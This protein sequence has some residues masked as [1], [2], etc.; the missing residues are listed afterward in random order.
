MCWFCKWETYETDLRR[1]YEY[2]IKCGT[3][4]IFNFDLGGIYG[5]QPMKYPDWEKGIPAILEIDKG[6][7]MIERP[8]HYNEDEYELNEDNEWV[9]KPTDDDIYRNYMNG[10]SDEVDIYG[11]K[12]DPWYKIDKIIWEWKYWRTHD[13]RFPEDDGIRYPFDP[14][15]VH[16]YLQQRIPPPKLQLNSSLKPSEFTLSDEKGNTLYSKSGSGGSSSSNTYLQPVSPN[17]RSIRM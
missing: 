4:R 8:L 10:M 17:R 5:Y 13:Y 14:I 1:S 2:C 16:E 6:D 7:N 11:V 15:P 12:N 3:R 9:R